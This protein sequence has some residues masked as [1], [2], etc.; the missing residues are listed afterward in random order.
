MKVV[1]SSWKA[2]NE[3]RTRASELGVAAVHVVARERGRVTEIL[4]ALEAIPASSVRATDPGDSHASAEWKIRCRSGDNLA[5]D[6]VARNQRPALGRQ[7]ALDNMQIGS[8]NP[9]STYLD[10][11]VAG[12]W[13]G[14]GYLNDFQWARRDASWRTQN[15]GLHRDPSSSYRIEGP[16]RRLLRPGSEVDSGAKLHRAVSAHRGDIAEGGSVLTHPCVRR[17]PQIP[18]DEVGLILA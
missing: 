2:N 9:A 6:L 12:Q 11:Y 5:D 16:S 13:F 4:A 3:I 18:E 10:H 8:T 15:G 7:F 1:K 14:L 17:A